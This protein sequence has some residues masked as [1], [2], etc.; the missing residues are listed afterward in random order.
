MFLMANIVIFSDNASKES[1][2][3][4]HTRHIDDQ[5]QLL[6]VAKCI[7]TRVFDLL[8]NLLDNHHFGRRSCLRCVVPR[9]QWR[10]IE[11]RSWKSAR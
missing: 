7:A 1:I 3:Y 9:W 4:L 11:V 8:D 10:I 2:I 6:G 5:T